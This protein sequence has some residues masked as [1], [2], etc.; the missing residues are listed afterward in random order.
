MDIALRYGCNPN[1]QPAQIQMPQGDTPLRVVNG[2]ASFIN[3]LD[4]L[5]GWQLVREL[6]QTTGKP[7]AASYKHVSPAGAA[8]AGPLSEVFCAGH[9]IDDGPNL[10][11][12][13][14]AYAKARSS[15][16]S[17]SFGDFV[18]LSQPADA[19]LARL[20]KPEVSDGIIA[21]GYEPEALE[22]IRAKKGGNYLMLEIDPGYEPPEME[23]RLEFGMRLSQKRNDQP[24]GPELL[25][26]VVTK[27][28]AFSPE[29][30]ETLLVATV[31][32]KHT[33]SNSV[34][35]G[36][37]GQ[38][39]G[40]GAGQQSRIACTR[41]AC[42]KAEAWLLKTHPR[43]LELPF[44]PGLKRA[45]KVNI[46]DQYVRWDELGPFER[47]QISAGL[48]ADPQPISAAERADYLAGFDHLA[49]SSDAFFPFRDNIDRLAR[50]GVRAVLQA[51][52]SKRDEDV[53]AAADE[54][55][56]TMAMSGVRFFLH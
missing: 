27:N 23:D 33:Q 52:G 53:V 16:R 50:T 21:P 5:R 48:T 34:A 14:S 44:R 28:K 19:S 55:G 43:T 38:A 49:C 31:T 12:I 2:A 9:L 24:I 56:M 29:A 30:I 17:A 46:I 32:L 41:L 37:A 8:V 18:A 11:P 20:L 6:A 51:G 45:E 4:A 15:D 39:V 7:A 35:L 36:Y 13:A 54:H 10:S 3:I 40:I 26:N 42:T 1:Q 22:I 47:E 25:G